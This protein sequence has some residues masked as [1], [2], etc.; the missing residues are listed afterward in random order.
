M[1]KRELTEQ[2]TVGTI[3]AFGMILPRLV[4]SANE[5]QAVTMAFSFLFIVIPT[6]IW[7]CCR[8]YQSVR[9]TFGKQEID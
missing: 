2:V 3:G 9:K 5:I 6:G 4:E 7:A 8:A 1:V